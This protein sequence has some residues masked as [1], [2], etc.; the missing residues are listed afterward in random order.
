MGLSREAPVSVIYH[1]NKLKNKKNMIISIDT[2]N[3]FNKTQHPFMTKTL[4]KVGMEGTYLNMIKPV[5]EKSSAN[6]IF[7]VKS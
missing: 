6:I 2:E 5:Y 1:I 3:V 4:Q 7:N